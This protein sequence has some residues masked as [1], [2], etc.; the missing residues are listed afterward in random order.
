M[1]TRT[2]PHRAASAVA[3]HSLEAERSVLGAI[4][5]SPAWLTAITLDVGL[6]SEEPDV[7]KPYVEK[8]MKEQPMATLGIA[9]IIGFVL[10]ALWKK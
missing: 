9:A 1:T 2:E 6:T 4:L 8:Q 10:G 7:V 3:P 5:L